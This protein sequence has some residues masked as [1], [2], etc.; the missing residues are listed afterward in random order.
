MLLR[1]AFVGNALEQAEL[2]NA[3]P[4]KVFYRKFRPTISDAC[5]LLS[6]LKQLGHLIGKY[7]LAPHTALEVWIIELAGSD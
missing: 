4:A 5:F 6:K 2:I 7:A 1:L 3:S